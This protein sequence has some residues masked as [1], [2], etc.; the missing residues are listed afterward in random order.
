VDNGIVSGR[1]DVIL[2]MEGGRINSLA[3]V[4]YKTASDTSGDDIHAFQ[5][6]VYAAA[7]RGEGL[8]VTAAYLHN[9]K[10]SKRMDLPVE[11]SQT[12]QAKERASKLISGIIQKD[13]PAKPEKSKCTGCDMRN[14]CKYS[15]GGKGC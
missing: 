10:T 15:K 9:L 6:A 11:D 13:F 4:D 1:A 2:D 14:I 7:G 12:N 8:N 3:L 5:L